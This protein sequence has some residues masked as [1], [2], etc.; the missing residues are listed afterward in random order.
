M[1]VLKERQQACG[2]HL[3]HLGRK[4]N[5]KAHHAFMV[6][7]ALSC[8][9]PILHGVDFN[10]FHVCQDSFYGVSDRAHPGLILLM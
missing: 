10:D 2:N 7:I 6:D 5:F 8:Y 1:L 9:Q 4:W 3:Y